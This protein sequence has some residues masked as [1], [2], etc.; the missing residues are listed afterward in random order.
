[1]IWAQN[2]FE[3]TSP[4]FEIKIQS[5]R[6]QSW[7]KVHG[8]NRFQKFLLMVNRHEVTIFFVFRL[9]WLRSV[10]GP[11]FKISWI[12]K[13]PEPKKLLKRKISFFMLVNLSEEFLKLVHTVALVSW[14]KSEPLTSYFQME[15]HFFKKNLGSNHY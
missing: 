7:K 9:F 14:S 2:F 1:M 11:F 10:F 5:F 8:M 13:W 4:H 15:E 3:K 12:K 6:K